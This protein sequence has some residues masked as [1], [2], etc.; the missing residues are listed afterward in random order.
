MNEEM[1]DLRKE[2]LD[3]KNSNN[4]LLEGLIS[5]QKKIRGVARK[6]QVV[7]ERKDSFDGYV[8]TCEDGRVFE[9]E[10]ITKA[11]ELKEELQ[12]EN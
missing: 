11:I 1:I 7:I 12:N 4:E 2:N 8:I 10:T 6:M 5:T 3:L 9:A